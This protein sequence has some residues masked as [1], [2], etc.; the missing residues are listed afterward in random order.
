MCGVTTISGFTPKTVVIEPK[1]LFGA[2][3]PGSG[4]DRLVRHLNMGTSCQV[5][6]ER[7]AGKTS[8]LTCGMARLVNSSPNVTALPNTR[9]ISDESDF[10]R[11]VL[12]EIHRQFLGKGGGDNEVNTILPLASSGPQLDEIPSRD[13]PKRLSD[14]ID[15]LGEQNRGVILLLDEYEL[16]IDKSF[17]G[18]VDRFWP[19]HRLVERPPL[20][21]GVKPLTVALAGAIDW[22]Q[23]CLNHG[24]PP[25]NFIG[26][27][28]RAE[29]LAAADFYA[30]WK[31][32]VSL[33]SD[34]DRKRLKDIDV[35][36]VYE[37]A[38]GW[39]FYGKVIGQHALVDASVDEVHLADVL[40]PHFEVIWRQRTAEEKRALADVTKERPH[41]SITELLRRGLVEQHQTG[42]PRIRGRLWGR[43]VAEQVTLE[44]V[45]SERMTEE[46]GIVQGRGGHDIPHYSFIEQNGVFEILFLEK[47]SVVKAIKGIGII[48]RL[49]KQPNPQ[50]ATS[51]ISLDDG[52]ER[53]VDRAATQEQLDSNVISLVRAKI[54]EIE[55]QRTCSCNQEERDDLEEAAAKY[56]EY[57]RKGT[58]LSGGS[59]KFE[60]NP[61]DRAKDNVRKA[62]QAA[63]AKLRDDLPELVQHLQGAIKTE[64]DGYAYRPSP[65]LHW[66]T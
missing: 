2:D 44:S 40:R 53:Q 36:Y 63:Y 33:C 17:A 14:Y 51:S 30:M 43:F 38:G 28:I 41:S 57:L 25:L 45:L 8:L 66:E 19:I 39:P 59:R 32:C 15:F 1:D 60:N 56:K 49:I 26:E 52:D 20:P 22:G 65:E 29:P 7:N 13:L 4:L 58:N 61:A 27:R 31:H 55:E 62:L 5:L 48:H 6:G 21:S 54:K 11:V 34:D 24:S 64:G 18:Q 3:R 16:I 46:M 12:G 35:A 10:Y 42:I 9:G 37:L 50:R 23:Y 47:R